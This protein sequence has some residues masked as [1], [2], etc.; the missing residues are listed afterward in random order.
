M[1]TIKQL[2]EE[3][4]ASKETAICTGVFEIGDRKVARVRL[5]TG[6]EVTVYLPAGAEVPE[7]SAEVEIEP[8]R[9]TGDHHPARTAF[10]CG[11]HHPAKVDIAAK[12]T[13]A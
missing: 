6:S 10:A 13:A 12:V 5:T 2:T 1:T 8:Q 4:R 7:I 9:T 11:D 3:R